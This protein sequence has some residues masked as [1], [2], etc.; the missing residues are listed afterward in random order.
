MNHG[1][2]IYIDTKAKCTVVIQKIL[3]VSEFI[4]PVL[5]KSSPKR[6][7]SMTEKRAFWDC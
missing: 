4:D 6:W 2:M 5:A 3:P 7:F 1:L